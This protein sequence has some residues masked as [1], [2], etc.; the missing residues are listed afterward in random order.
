MNLKLSNKNFYKKHN[1]NLSRYIV[2]ENFVHFVGDNNSYFRENKNTYLVAAESR[3]LEQVGINNKVDT[4]IFTDYFESSNNIYQLLK[5]SK[6]LLSPQGKLIVSVTNFRYSFLVKILERLGLK[7]TSPSLSQIHEN[8][9]K[10]LA[11]TTGL[12]FITSYTKQIIPFK[13]FGLASIINLILEIVFSKFN[14][15]IIR[16]IVFK[17]NETLLNRE[18]TK[19][20]IVPAKNEAGNIETL[21][22]ELSKIKLDQVIFSLGSSSDNTEQLVRDYMKQFPNINTVCHIQSNKGKANAIWESLE[23]VTEEVVAI[24]DADISVEPNE[25]KNFFQIIDNNYA[26]FVNGT[27]LIYPMEKE[28]MRKLNLIGNRVFQKVVSFITNEKL[29]DSLCGTKVFKK[30]FIPKLLWWQKTF[31]L[32]D[33]FCDFD[34]LFAASYT[35]EKIVEYPIHYKSRTYGKTQISRFRD[36]FKLIIYLIK[37]FFIFHTSSIKK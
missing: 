7:K 16:Y 29:S 1:E 21:F 30:D 24:L 18:Y 23:I 9:I 34:L 22:L 33:P 35:G 15:G 11:Q 26:D 12:E 17:N 20:V 31:S 3:L 4:I 5:D 25:L 37:S 8:H 19:T 27:R 28:S 10:N 14:L 2:N 36:G 6:S 32:F 13:V